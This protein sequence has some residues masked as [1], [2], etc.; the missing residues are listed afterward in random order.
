MNN[1]Q[2]DVQINASKKFIEYYSTIVDHTR[3]KQHYQFPVTNA[4]LKDPI[5]FLE[6]W[7]YARFLRFDE[8]YSSFEVGVPREFLLKVVF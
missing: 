8:E 4:I 7:L 6:N 5:V 2:L 3:E 1:L